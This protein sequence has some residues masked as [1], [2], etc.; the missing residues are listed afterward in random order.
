MRIIHR[1]IIFAAIIMIFLL[2]FACSKNFQE[3]NLIKLGYIGAI[4]GG[5]VSITK[6]EING[7]EMALDETN[8]SNS[9]LGG[10]KL[11][12]IQYDDE[13]DVTKSVIY[14]Q[15]LVNQDKVLFVFGTINSHT[16]LADLPIFTK[17]GIGQMTG[18]AAADITAKGS[19]YIFRNTSAGPVLEKTLVYYLIKNGFKRF[20]LISDTSAYGKNEADYQQAALRNKG[21]NSL[22]REAYNPGETNFYTQLT[23]ILQMNPEVILFGALAVDSSLIAKQARQLGFKGQFAG[24]SSIG[25][26][27]FIEADNKTAEGVIFSSPYIDN[28]RNEM[29]RDFAQKFKAKWGYDPAAHAARG[30]DG[31]KMVIEAIKRVHGKLSSEAISKE[32][33]G[34]KDYQGLQ[35][36]FTYQEN[37]EG[38]F[39]CQV[40]IIKNGKL[41]A[42]KED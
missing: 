34:V 17:A 2:Y 39:E 37:G 31:A 3:K 38:I 6:S 4:S 23:N 1:I 5:S 10:R 21:L 25:T 18:V 14:A 13:S 11:K 24:G 12:L 35:G 36:V 27:T 9:F 19:S 26:P 30:Y 41:T 28:N 22:T 20:A 8:A 29:T 7:I 16:S 15:K 33:H 40:G 42:V 32:L